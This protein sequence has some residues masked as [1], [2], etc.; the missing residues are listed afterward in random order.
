MWKGGYYL[1][2]KIQTWTLHERIFVFWFNLIASQKGLSL[3]D[4]Q[5]N[6]GIAGRIAELAGKH[7]IHCQT[8]NI[9]ELKFRFWEKDKCLSREEISWGSLMHRTARASLHKHSHPP[10]KQW[11]HVETAAW[12]AGKIDKKKTYETCDLPPKYTAVPERYKTEQLVN[13]LYALGYMQLFQIL[14]T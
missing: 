5:Q 3:R 6:H 12:D 8:Q 2:D 1:L 9:A 11:Q 13:N 10:H 14:S 4:F 7:W